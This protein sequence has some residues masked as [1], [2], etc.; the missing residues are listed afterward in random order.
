MILLNR[1]VAQ[2][3]DPSNNVHISKGTLVKQKDRL[4]CDTIDDRSEPADK[5]DF[6]SP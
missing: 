1:H 3:R 4:R 2:A 5:G 6:N